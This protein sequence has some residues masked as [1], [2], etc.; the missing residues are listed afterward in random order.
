MSTTRKGSGWELLQSWWILLTLVPTLNGPA[1]LIAGL[2][3]RRAKLLIAGALYLGLTVA[4]VAYLPGTEEGAAPAAPWVDY[5]IGAWF[6][7][8]PVSFIHA[9]LS[10]KEYL[11]LAEARSEA[12]SRETD[13]LRTRVTASAGLSANR[14]DEQLVD[15]NDNDVTVR[16]LRTLFGVL[17]FAPDFRTYFNVEG[18]VRRL[19]PAA[20]ASVVQRATVIAAEEPYAQVVKTGRALDA[21]DSGLGVFTGIKNVYDR[22]KEKN[23]RTFEADPQQAADAAIKALSIGYMITRLF[24]GGP[25]D[26]VK[27]FL[28]LP[29]G[30]ELALYFA[31]VELALP[32]TDNLM[33]EGAQL[34]GRI[35]EQHRPAMEQRFS[36]FTNAS[37]AQE[38]QSVLGE[39]TARV[40]QALSQVKLYVDPLAQKLQAYMPSIMNAADSVSGGIAT[41]VDL[42]PAYRLLCARLAA[43]A[44]ARKAL[45]A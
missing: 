31:S 42:L 6:L 33:E 2:L 43:E 35:I 24:P 37:A 27:A 21:I 34:I 25:V 14:I 20:D 7:A 16:L 40:G 18:A 45:Q 15:F 11:I 3:V 10:R 30:Q 4:F 38:A 19:N 36:S 9:L 23:Q 5:L 12:S 28:D 1:F 39:L 44:A 8:W 32:F 26:K 41:A 17:P 22:I 13:R 29:A